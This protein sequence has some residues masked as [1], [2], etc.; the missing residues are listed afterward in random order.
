MVNFSYSRSYNQEGLNVE[1]TIRDES[2]G[3]IETF[4][5]RASEF[6]KIAHI[7]YKKYGIR[8]KPEVDYSLGIKKPKDL[9]WV[10]KT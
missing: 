6:H 5:C 2:M 1:V 10:N 8:Y 9:E 3:K 7:L 4:R